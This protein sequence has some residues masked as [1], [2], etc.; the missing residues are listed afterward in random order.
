MG[1]SSVE[2][3]TVS[4]LVPFEDIFSKVYDDDKYT[5]PVRAGHINQS[6]T[7]FGLCAIPFYD[8]DHLPVNVRGS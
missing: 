5:M 8:T 3:P 6:S 4:L 2:F 7:S 1:A